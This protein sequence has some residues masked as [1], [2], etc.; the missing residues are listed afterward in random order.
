[1]HHSKDRTTATPLLVD[2]WAHRRRPG[3]RWGFRSSFGRLGSDI[4][5]TCP[6]RT[7][8]AWKSTP[9]GLLL[10]RD[11]PLSG[12]PAPPCRLPRCRDLS[13][14]GPR[15]FPQQE[16]GVYG[17]ATAFPRPALHPI[18]SSICAVPG[19]HTDSL[20]QAGS[21]TGLT[22]SATNAFLLAPVPTPTPAT[23]AGRSPNSRPCPLCGGTARPPTY[24]R[25]GGGRVCPPL[26]ST[27]PPA[28]PNHNAYG[29][30]C[31]AD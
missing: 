3:P 11:R 12:R 30:G 17:W 18:P 27:P 5:P 24:T 22:P 23:S 16:V 19:F 4:P 10:R 13:R 14:R 21:A 6:R 29:A 25:P 15:A 1:M 9:P 26:S 20:R 28:A 31:P 7:E 2:T 8:A